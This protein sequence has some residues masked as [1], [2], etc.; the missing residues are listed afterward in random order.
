MRRAIRCPLRP[1]HPATAPTPV[2]SD[3]IE[4]FSQQI[5]ENLVDEQ[6]QLQEAE[7]LDIR[8]EDSEIQAAVARIERQNGLA[9]GQLIN[10][11]TSRNVD[12]NTLID[13]IRATLA[14]RK[15]V[16]LRL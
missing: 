15:T 5:I 13:Q 10:L 3:E 7:R 9:S 16:E 2:G 1:S 4:R 11:L 14:W 6:L 8:V 12:A